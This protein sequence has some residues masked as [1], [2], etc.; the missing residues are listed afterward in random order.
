VGDSVAQ[1]GRSVV[2]TDLE[3]R[4]R[5]NASITDE[6]VDVR[7][8]GDHPYASITDKSIVARTVGDHLYVNITG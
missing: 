7:I 8:V 2:N 4:K 3:S 5:L 1:E 6:S